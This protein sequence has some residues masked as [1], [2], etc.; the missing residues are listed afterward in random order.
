MLIKNRTKRIIAGL[1]A[2]PDQ[3]PYQA[4]IRFKDDHVLLCGGTIIHELYIL[5]AA[6]CFEGDDTW[7]FPKDL[8]VKVGTINFNDDPDDELDRNR[9]FNVIEYYV[10]LNFHPETLDSDIAI[11]KVSVTILSRPEK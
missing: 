7:D 11:L 4:M 8:E 5:T 9:T 1:P 10:S 3:F 2:E 6:H